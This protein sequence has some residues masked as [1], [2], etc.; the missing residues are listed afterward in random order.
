LRG[1]EEI[2]AGRIADVR[3]RETTRRVESGEVVGEGRVAFTEARGY[4]DGVG[5]PGART[6]D[7]RAKAGWRGTRTRRPGTRR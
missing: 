7:L 2:A 6:P 4:P 1:E 5:V 3:G